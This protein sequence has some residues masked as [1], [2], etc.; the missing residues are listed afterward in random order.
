VFVLRA[1]EELVPGVLVGGEQLRDFLAKL[2][3]VTTRIQQVAGAFRRME[4][5][6]GIEKVFDPLPPVAVRVDWLRP[7]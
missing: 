6:R 1:V 2:G 3:I 4:I 5:E 7:G